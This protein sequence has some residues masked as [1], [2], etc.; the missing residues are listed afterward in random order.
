M[1]GGMIL[2]KLLIFF[3]ILLVLLI[4]GIL[5]SLV[6]EEK[7]H[8]YIHNV[9]HDK[10]TNLDV[11]FE[12]IHKKQYLIRKQ[13]VNGDT[14]GTINSNSTYYFVEPVTLIFDIDSKFENCSTYKEY[15]EV[16]SMTVLS[17][18][19]DIECHIIKGSSSKSVFLFADTH[20]LKF[21]IKQ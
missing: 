7:L 12:E 19:G 13:I 18:G 17:W 5:P 16:D 15:D 21:K 6:S 11:I 4:I 10:K 8:Q 1:G 3:G 14:T 9:Y 2:D 20:R